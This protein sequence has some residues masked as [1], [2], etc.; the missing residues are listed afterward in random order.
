MKPAQSGLSR[1]SK[2]RN[3]KSEWIQLVER[4]GCEGEGENER[5]GLRTPWR[6]LFSVAKMEKL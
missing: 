4:L 1:D 6:V 3:Q 2:V 5:I